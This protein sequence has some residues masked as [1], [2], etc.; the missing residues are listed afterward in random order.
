MAVETY[1]PKKTVEIS[2]A[3]QKRVDAC[4]PFGV[5][6]RL[7][8]VLL[9]TVC[10]AVEAHGEIALGAILARKVSVLDL[11]AAYE[12]KEVPGGQTEQG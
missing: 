10:T 1:R 6:R 3:L 9:D 4:I 7:F 11:I 8:E 2:E 12:P 5:G